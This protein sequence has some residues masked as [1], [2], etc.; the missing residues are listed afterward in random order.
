MRLRGAIAALCVCALAAASGCRTPATPST[1][2]AK[3]APP[4]ASAGQ[5]PAGE[6]N[7][8]ANPNSSAN[9]IQQVAYSDDVATALDD[10]PDDLAGVEE[11]A[12][13][14]LVQPEPVLAPEALDLGDGDP[15]PTVVEVVDSVRNHFP[16]IREAAAGRVVASGERL[17]AEG[18]FDLNLDGY[19]NGQPLDFFENS[20]HVYSLKRKTY[21]GGEVGAGYRLGRGSFEPWYLERETNDGGEFS[22]TLSAPIG[23]DQVIDSNRDKLWRAQLEQDRIEPV[24]RAQVIRSVRD[25][26]IA[27]WEWVAADANFRIAEGV[28]QLGLDRVEF[29]TRK[30]EVKELAPIE[31]D[32]NRRLIVSRQ[33]KLVDA[34][35]KREQ[36]AVKL[37]LFLRT[38]EGMPYVPQGGRGGEI[39]QMVDANGGVLAGDI[40][41][42]V[43][44]RPELAELSVVRRQLGIALN[45]ARNETRPD[46]DGGMLLAQDVGNPTKS[47]NKSDFELEATLTLSV[48]LQRRAALGKVR[49]LRGKLAQVRAKT[50]FA[51]EKVIAEVLAARAGLTAAAQRIE[52]TTEGVRLAERLRDAERKLYDTGQSTLLNLNLREQQAVEAAVALVG[53]QF[54]YAVAQA[55]YAAALGLER[56]AADLF[57]GDLPPIRA[58]GC[59]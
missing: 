57:D 31:L 25:G 36:T 24:V 9:E 20:W 37:S 44:N 38:P 15:P 10:G 17:S 3:P 21:W 27:Y 48:P 18:A 12:A 13:P 54:D 45:Q 5:K 35:R 32:D 42:A 11:L 30:V 39:D 1:V 28:L 49:Q 41:Y 40:D 59:H 55:D 46:L 26:V 50:Q 4:A 22:V 43:A 23:R 47:N 56:G 52:Q 34:R 58:Y 33:E 51:R 29:L 16:A 2:F 6:A 7:S 8:S 53:A 19:T 14:D